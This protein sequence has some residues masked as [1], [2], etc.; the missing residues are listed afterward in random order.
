MSSTPVLP[1]LV[2]GARRRL[3]AQLLAVGVGQA[4]CTISTAL[5]V[6]RAFDVLVHQ[7][8][9]P[10]RPAAVLVLLAGLV[11]CAVTAGVLRA[12]ER[13]TAE[14]LGQDY[15]LHVRDA[16][17]AHLVRVPA[18]E[19]GRLGRGG[20]LLR[21]VGDLSAL[22]S[23]VSLGL[24][25]LLVG[26]CVVVLSTAAL[27][28]LDRRLGVAVGAVLLVGAAG[29]RWVQPRLT[30]A[31]RTARDRRAKLTGEVAERLG[32]IAVVQAAGQE[33]R[34]ERRVRRLG[35]RAVDAATGR[36]AAVG[37]ARGTAE[38]TAALATVAALGAGALAVR[39][40]DTTPGSVVAATTVAGLLA[41]HLR[42]LGRVAELATGARVAR[43]AALRFLAVPTL[44]VARGARDLEVTAGEVRLERI[45]VRGAL[46]D[47]T[48][49]AAPGVFT[50]VVGP[51]GAGKSTLVALLARLAD[52]DTGAVLV[53]GQD[54]RDVDPASVRRAV[55]TAATDLPPLRG[56]LRRNVT[57]RLP[58]CEDAEL[59][60]VARLC[61]L[62]ALAAELPGGW[63]G[64][65]GEGGSR[66]SAG[67][68]ARVVIARAALGR[69]PLLVLDEAD[70]HLDAAAAD[71]VDRVLADH[72]GTAVVVTHRR[73][74]VERA[75][76]VWCLA[77]GRVAET[78]TPAEL[79]GRDG[80]TARLFGPAGVTAWNGA[81]AGGRHG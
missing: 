55:G 36:A 33:R 14:R 60:R 43:E 17:F 20:M 40:G 26:G 79:L 16:L 59:R 77:G 74:L 23:W 81:R 78:G 21:F 22:R 42:D 75:D 10:V 58:R 56:S 37:A 52:P 72:R 39:A 8:A 4:A 34:E 51:N 35:E 54:L 18:R 64:D 73:A 50:A 47:V 15:A 45:G 57:Y 61:D 12:A 7:A 28:V 68:R 70:A 31:T 38:A 66:L 9:V 71:V 30:A 62:D 24:A 19:V 46:R 2:T 65:V 32:R 3:F 1:P 5:L 69:P 6:R 11:L 44:P 67:Q 13:V 41:G 63:D 76:Q 80:P 53:D 25:R 48:L 27:C 29:T 49:R